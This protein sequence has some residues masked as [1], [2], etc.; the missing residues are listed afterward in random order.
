MEKD[1]KEIQTNKKKLIDEIKSIDKDKMFVVKPKER[2]SIFNKIL[3]T[4][5]Y[6]KKR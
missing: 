2:I 4:L 3:I 1:K 5:G 6:G